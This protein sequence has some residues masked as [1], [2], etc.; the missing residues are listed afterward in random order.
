MFRE[1]YRKASS[2]LVRCRQWLGSARRAPPAIGVEKSGAAAP[3]AVN[4]NLIYVDALNVAY[5][6][7]NPP[8]LRMPVTLLAQLIA[9]GYQVLIYFDASARYRLGDEAGLYERLMQHSRFCIEVPSG[10]SADAVMLR[11][12]NTNGARVLS[13]DKYRDHRR[14][15]RRLIDDPARLMS[16]GVREGRLRV[17]ALSLD[18]ALPSSAEEALTQLESLLF[19]Q[20]Q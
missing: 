13:K 16:G 9:D 11:Q 3:K 7:G 15:Y 19:R 17:P 18:V 12:A 14:R 8:S 1:L 4:A 6:R 10:K 2:W 20:P 5:W